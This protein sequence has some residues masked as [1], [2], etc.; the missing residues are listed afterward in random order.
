MEVYR[1]R[2]KELPPFFGAPVTDEAY[3]FA[4]GRLTGGLLFCRG[5]E[6]Y[7]RLKD[8]LVRIYGP[9]KNPKPDTYVW[10][11]PV[12]QTLLTIVYNRKVQYGTIS[13]TSGAG[14]PPGTTEKKP[15]R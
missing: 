15:P 11:W 3:D 8:S 4:R 12:T 6:N 10:E 9:P 1:N 13:M 2:A 7:N 5:E 14:S